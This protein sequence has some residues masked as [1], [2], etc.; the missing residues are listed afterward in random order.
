MTGVLIAPVVSVTVVKSG[1]GKIIQVSIAEPSSS[2]IRKVS[3][4]NEQ[5][6]FGI[7]FKDIQ[8]KVKNTLKY[9]LNGLREQTKEQLLLLT[10]SFIDDMSC[11]KKEDKKMCNFAGHREKIKP[12]N[13]KGKLCVPDRQQFSE[14]KGGDESNLRKRRR[15]R[16]SG[17]GG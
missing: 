8:P 2:V 17:K 5:K 14:F 11:D 13:W 16:R 7:S 3:A 4:M 9:T 1:T 10:F 15:R 6:L 12:A